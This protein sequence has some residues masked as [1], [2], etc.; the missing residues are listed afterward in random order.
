M[1]RRICLDSDVLIA[2][3]NRDEKTKQ[4]IE[5]LDADFYI[6]TVNTFEVWYGRKKT[7]PVFEALE[8]LHSLEMDDKAAR[9]AGDILR[10]LK[11]DG[12]MIDIRDMFIGAIC[13][14]NDIELLTYNKKHFERLKEFGLVLVETA[15]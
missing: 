6:T 1:V 3:L 10:K 15:D 9:L 2:L 4:I 8:W 14:N 12:R 5:A 7:E 13:I 11:D